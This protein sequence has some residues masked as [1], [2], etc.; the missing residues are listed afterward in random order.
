MKRNTS[1]PVK[2]MT[3]LSLMFSYYIQ[4]YAT[5]LFW[6]FFKPSAIVWSI[7]DDSKNLLF[8]K[9]KTALKMTVD[10]N[11][12]RTSWNNHH[13]GPL[14]I[15]K[16]TKTKTENKQIRLRISKQ[17]HVRL[18]LP[19]P[20]HIWFSFPPLLAHFIKYIFLQ[21]RGMTDVKRHAQSKVPLCQ[22]LN[23]CKFLKLYLV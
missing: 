8:F 17:F 7:L 2:T 3:P 16:Q 13:R 14:K 15:W 12:L 19:I 20:L 11:S 1:V 4:Y 10:W 22:T 18:I 9:G 5:S 23:A 6:C 21:R